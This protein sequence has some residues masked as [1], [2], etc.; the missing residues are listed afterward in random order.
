LI[1]TTSKPLLVRP[2]QHLRK[3]RPIRPKPLIATLITAACP[4]RSS[5]IHKK[6]IN[7]PNHTLKVELYDPDRK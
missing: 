7:V 6:I 1:P 4:L 3:L 5:A 2:N